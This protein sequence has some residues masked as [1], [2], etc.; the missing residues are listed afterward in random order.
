MKG[1]A[2]DDSD[3][4]S[5]D[6]R[7]KVV[8][9]AKS[10]RVDEVDASV[11]A[12]ENAGKINDWVSISNGTSPPSQVLERNSP[13]STFFLEFD[14]LV[15]L[16]SRQAN[17]SDGIPSGFYKILSNLDEMLVS[18]QGNRKKMNA[19]NAKALNSM[20]QKVKKTQREHESQL[21]KYKAVSFS[22]KCESCISILT[23]L[24]RLLPHR[25]PRVSRRRL[26]LPLLLLPH[27]KPSRRL[28]LSMMMKMVSRLLALPRVNPQLLPFRV[29][30]ST[31]LSL[32]SWNNVVAR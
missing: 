4:S 5:D 27:L 15:R 31:R 22:L 19:T 21:N 7:A 26:K 18:A 32:R 17:T 20:K 2:S 12:I 23:I 13:F 10:K 16:V 24:F 3:D 6:E 9:S 14:K 29:R 28:P 25:I 30:V 11:K 8:K 1:A